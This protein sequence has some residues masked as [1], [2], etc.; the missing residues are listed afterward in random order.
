MLRVLS[1]H[2]VDKILS[3]CIPVLA[4]CPPPAGAPGQHQWRE[5]GPARFVLSNR[6]MTD[7]L[8]LTAR[9]AGVPAICVFQQGQFLTGAHAGDFIDADAVAIGRCRRDRQVRRGHLA[10]GVRCDGDV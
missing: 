4:R 1:N 7:N 3:L 9:R 10:E 5:P 6:A 2:V 8:L